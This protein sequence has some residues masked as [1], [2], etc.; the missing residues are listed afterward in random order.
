M[1]TSYRLTIVGLFVLLVA[2]SYRAAEAQLFWDLSVKFIDDS[3]R[4]PGN[5]QDVPASNDTED[6]IV[7]GVAYANAALDRFG[8][9]YRFRLKDQG[10][11]AFTSVIQPTVP[12][13]A[14]SSANA[15]WEFAD[16][17]ETTLAALAEAAPQLTCVGGASSSVFSIYHPS[18]YL[19]TYP[20]T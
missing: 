13:P 10:G 15:S 14:S 11:G 5:C 3:A 18:I 2:P 20:P 17:D 1:M 12:P 8:R 7:A 16:V 9:G 19:P 6:E 4:S